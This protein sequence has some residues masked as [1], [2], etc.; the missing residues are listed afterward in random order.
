[1]VY[2]KELLGPLAEK[3]GLQSWRAEMKKA[4][5]AAREENWD[6]VVAPAKR[7]IEIYPDYTQSGSPYVMLAEAYEEQGDKKA[8]IGELL[9]YFQRGGREPDELAT[10]V[11]DELLYVWPADEE[12]HADLGD[13]MLA[14]NRHQEALREFNVLLSMNPHDKAAAYYRLAETYHKMN[15]SQ[16]ARRNLLMSLEIAPTY[17]PAQRLLLEIAR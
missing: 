7:A 5:A 16:R 3:Q 6:D 11:L 12:L 13:W 4:A 9:G 10:A 8:A 17:K 2:A 1:L 15:D 14:D